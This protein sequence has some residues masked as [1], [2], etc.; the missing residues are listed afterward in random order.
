MSNIDMQFEFFLSGG[1]DLSLASRLGE[2]RFCC[3]GYRLCLS[4]YERLFGFGPG[5]LLVGKGVR[6]FC[7]LVVCLAGLKMVVVGGGHL[8]DCCIE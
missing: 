7:G 4:W 6:G 3:E 5:A 2:W 1:R 8:W